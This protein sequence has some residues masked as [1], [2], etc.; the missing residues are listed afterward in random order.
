MHIIAI[1][2]VHGRDAWEEIKHKP[3]DQ[4]IFI[5]DYV[6]PHRPIPD[7][8]VLRNFEEII[9]FKK[10]DP[11]RITLLL[12]NHDAQYLHYPRY[13]C[14]GH[15]AD[16]QET[17]GKLF[18]ENEGLFQ[19]AWQHEGY[20]FTHAG[21]SQSWY[22]HHLETLNDFGKKNLAA[23]LNAIH[24]SE[25]RDILFEV[26][27]SRGGWHRHGGPIWADQSETRHDYLADYNQI[28]GHSRVKDFE[29]YG[30]ETSSITYIDVGDTQVRF[31]E[32]ELPESFELSGS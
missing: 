29:Y 8:E 4:I 11:G 6:D 23:A 20:L 30:D 25:Y 13:P 1:G 18:L 12:G 21:L 28:V 14:S 15:R 3:A 10:S 19:I 31:F 24:K 27:R 17:L 7:F 2:D 32:I 16:L 5:G 9:A 26:G 22:D